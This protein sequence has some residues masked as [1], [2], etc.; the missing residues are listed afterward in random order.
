ML[1]YYVSEICFK[2]ILQEKLSSHKILT[3]EKFYMDK[4]IEI[5]SSIK[6]QTF[7]YFWLYLWTLSSFLV[8]GILLYFFLCKIKNSLHYGNSNRRIFKKIRVFIYFIILCVNTLT[9]NT[10]DYLDSMN[11]PNVFFFL[12]CFIYNTIP[13]MYYF[14]K[15]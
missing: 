1:N 5:Y 11:T 15:I 8:I 7:I 9:K 12:V 6:L 2:N 4:T 13:N 3:I 10:T 14:Y